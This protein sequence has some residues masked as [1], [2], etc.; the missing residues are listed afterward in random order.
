MPY[1]TDEIRLI[2][3]TTTKFYSEVEASFSATRQHEWEG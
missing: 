1:S 2:N 3:Q